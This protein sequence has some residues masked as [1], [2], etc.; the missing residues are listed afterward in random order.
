MLYKNSKSMVRSPDGDTGFFKITSGVLQG[1]TLAPYLFVICLDYALRISA[2]KHSELGLTLEER[3]SSRHP[4]KHMT[5]IDFADDLALLANTI[6]EAEKLLHHIELAAREVG[7]H[8][9]AKKTEYMSINDAGLM[10]SLDDQII[11]EVLDF[12]YLGSNVQSSEK[13]MTIWITKAWAALNK[14]TSIWKSNL[15]DDL[16]R[17]FTPLCLE[18]Y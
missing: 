4:A 1:D 14:L 3:R 18:L 8:I 2:D 16:K 10:K 11:K 12:V 7:L 9:N 13:D 15:P 5:D 6:E 17:S